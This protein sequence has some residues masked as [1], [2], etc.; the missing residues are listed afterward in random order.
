MYHIQQ[1][2]FD[3]Y[4]YANTSINC[5]HPIAVSLSQL[6]GECVC[7]CVCGG[8]G[9]VTSWIKVFLC[10]IFQCT[11]VTLY[12]LNILWYNDSSLNGYW[13]KIWAFPH[14]VFP[15]D[16]PAVWIIIKLPIVGSAVFNGVCQCLWIVVNSLF[17][18]FPTIWY[19]TRV[20]AKD[21]W[22]IKNC[23]NPRMIISRWVWGKLKDHMYVPES[24]FQLCMTQDK[25]AGKVDCMINSKVT[26]TIASYL[27]II[28]YG[29]VV[30][31]GFKQT[32]E[33]TAQW[34][35]VII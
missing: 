33:Q 1:N 20:T 32:I 18:M 29:H 28:G 4:S 8:G 30:C 5:V 14:F 2:E 10:I 13:T 35:V 23:E 9:G 25:N 26:L 11:I 24:R 3:Q 17:E 16:S 31:R 15:A 12:S 21:H 7:V 6:D 27:R 22:V 34:T 19:K